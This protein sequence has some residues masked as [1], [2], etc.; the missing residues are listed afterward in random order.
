MGKQNKQEL[1]DKIGVGRAKGVKRFLEN[2]KAAGDTPEQLQELEDFNVDRYKNEKQKTLEKLDAAGFYKKH[3]QYI[4]TPLP[5]L[6]QDEWGQIGS[7]MDFLKG[8]YKQGYV[9]NIEKV[10]DRAEKRTEQETKDRAIIENIKSGIYGPATTALYNAASFL[11]DVIKTKGTS[12]RSKFYESG[13]EYGKTKRNP[14]DDEIGSGW[15][16]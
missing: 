7:T 8:E 9:D 2:R 14:D 12:D 13:T 16:Y 11:G 10:F 1:E 3:Q 4:S 6:S 5:V 15:W